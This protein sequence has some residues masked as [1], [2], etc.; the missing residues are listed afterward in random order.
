ME[1]SR[2]DSRSGERRRH[3][4]MGLLGWWVILHI[5]RDRWRLSESHTLVA[6]DM[7][8]GG[9][10]GGKEEGGKKMVEPLSLFVVELS[11]VAEGLATQDL[12]TKCQVPWPQQSICGAVGARYNPEVY[13][14]T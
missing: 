7:V 12:V 3:E 6:F 2:E 9:V 14:L 11:V 8:G 10:R 4:W 13:R 1:R 5:V